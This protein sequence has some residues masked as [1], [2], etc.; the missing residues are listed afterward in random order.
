MRHRAGRIRD[1]SSR[2]D[3]LVD[4][5]IGGLIGGIVGAIAAV[6]FVIFSGMERGYESTIPEIF[7]QSV[8]AGVVTVALLAAGPLVGVLLRRRRR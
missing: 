5:L 1:M 4:V 2:R 7:T 8:P 6:N 3:W